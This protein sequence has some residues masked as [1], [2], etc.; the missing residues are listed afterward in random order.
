VRVVGGRPLGVVLV[1]LAGASTPISLRRWL[2]RLTG[3]LPAQQFCCLVLRVLGG[4]LG[5]RH[6][7]ASFTYQVLI[8]RY[9]VAF[10]GGTCHSTAPY[11]GC[12]P[13]QVTAASREILT[14][15]AGE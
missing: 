6:D 3:M 8:D 15:R 12:G 14:S 11:A 9:G 7:V 1:A 10:A 5:L 4:L 2:R 13:G